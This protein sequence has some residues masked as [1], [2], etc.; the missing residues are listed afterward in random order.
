MSAS[1]AARRRLLDRL[2]KDIRRIY[3]EKPANIMRDRRLHSDEERLEML[4]AWPSMD[5]YEDG[6]VARLKAEITNKESTA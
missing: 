6:E 2:K 3:S 4:A 5:G 1:K